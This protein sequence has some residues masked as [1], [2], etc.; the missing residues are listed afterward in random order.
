[1]FT[2][3]LL[4]SPDTSKS[5]LIYLIIPIQF[6]NS[7]M[8]FSKY[9]STM[10]NILCGIIASIFLFVNQDLLGKKLFDFMSA[11]SVYTICLLLI[12]ILTA[13]ISRNAAGQTH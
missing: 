12:A 11:S 2:L 8:F 7:Y 1:M 5:H 13:M 6:I 3:M 9:K 10:Y 4:V